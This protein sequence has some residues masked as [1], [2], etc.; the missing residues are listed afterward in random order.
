[1]KYLTI[2]KEVLDKLENIVIQKYKDHF[3]ILFT[4]DYKF[5][6]MDSEGKY[7]IVKKIDGD[8]VP[9]FYFIPYEELNVKN[10]DE[11]LSLLV[12]NPNEIIKILTKTEY[13]VK[14]LVIVY[15]N[16]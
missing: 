2:S 10:L 1:V 8:N 5:K 7:I 13:D 15:H 14:E 16:Y 11:L 12:R 6:V 3:G 9:D 4:L